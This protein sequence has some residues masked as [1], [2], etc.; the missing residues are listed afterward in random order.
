M[1]IFFSEF[2]GAWRLKGCR[3][4]GQSAPA[5]YRADGM[6]DWFGQ[7][8]GTYREE[9]IRQDTLPQNFPLLCR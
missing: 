3:P 2:R 1:K 6:E 5:H 4:Y 9:L 7:D 8:W